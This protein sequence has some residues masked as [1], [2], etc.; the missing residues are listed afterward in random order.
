MFADSSQKSQNNIAPVIYGV[1]GPDAHKTS[2]RGRGIVVAA[3]ELIDVA[4]VQF[5]VER[6]HKERRSKC[7]RKRVLGAVVFY[8]KVDA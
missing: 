6:Q 1:T 5:V 4:I 7:I 8:T 3:D 2:T